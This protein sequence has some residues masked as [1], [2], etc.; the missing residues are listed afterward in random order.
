MMLTRI[1]TQ[2]IDMLV[3]FF[4]AEKRAKKQI[5]TYLNEATSIE[6]LERRYKELGI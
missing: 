3:D 4:D 5:E 2:L 1:Y 6:D